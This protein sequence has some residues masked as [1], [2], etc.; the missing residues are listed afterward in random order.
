[1]TIAGY[2][3]II[4]SETRKTKTSRKDLKKGKKMTTI[5]NFEAFKKSLLSATNGTMV[6]TFDASMVA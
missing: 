3:S 6:E 5:K 1:M 4:Q 2:R